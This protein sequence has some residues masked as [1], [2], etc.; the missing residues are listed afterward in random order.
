MQNLGSKLLNNIA[1]IQAF[2]EHRRKR[3][4]AL[5]DKN[6]SI[7]DDGMK[8]AIDILELAMKCVD[9]SPTLRP[10]MIEVASELEKISNVNTSQDESVPRLVVQFV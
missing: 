10:T 5:V 4:F 3:L 6:I 1:L 9:Q 2:V 7:S 8:Q